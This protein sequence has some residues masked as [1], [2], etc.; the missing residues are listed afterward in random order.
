MEGDPALT[1]PP[2]C[3]VKSPIWSKILSIF[4]DRAI[5]RNS[6]Y[7]STPRGSANHCWDLRLLASRE[8]GSGALT[9]PRSK[10]S[11]A[12]KRITS[13]IRQRSNPYTK[14]VQIVVRKVEK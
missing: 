8:K 1:T 9:Q 5:F 11:S 12:L 10:C 3:S 7:L 4:L 2:F 6:G 14:R 13:Q